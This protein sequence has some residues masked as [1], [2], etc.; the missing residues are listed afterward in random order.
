VAVARKLAVLLHRLWVS[1]EL[2]DPLYSTHRRQEQ[3]EEVA[4][5]EAREH[6]EANEEELKSTN[7]AAR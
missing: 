6:S 1:G 7:T 4:Y 5:R 2:Y 3:E